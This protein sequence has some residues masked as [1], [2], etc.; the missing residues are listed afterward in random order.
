MNQHKISASQAQKEAKELGLHAADIEQHRKT[1]EKLR[2]DNAR[3]HEERDKLHRRY[4]D[5]VDEHERRLDEAHRAHRET[6]DKH[7][8]LQREFDDHKRRSE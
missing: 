5:A 8:R 3:H 2:D 1:N 7:G 6:A 4:K